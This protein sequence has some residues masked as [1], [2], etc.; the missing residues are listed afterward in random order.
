M[1][2][3]QVWGYMMNGMGY[4]LHSQDHDESLRVRGGIAMLVDPTPHVVRSGT[5]V[6]G[7]SGHMKPR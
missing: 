6:V 4:S 7:N 2:L 3:G 5:P 1:I